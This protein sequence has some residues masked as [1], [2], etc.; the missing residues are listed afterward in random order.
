MC[1]KMVLQYSSLM[2]ATAILLELRQCTVKVRRPGNP[3]ELTTQVSGV[4]CLG[5][6]AKFLR[7]SVSF[8]WQATSGAGRVPWL[9]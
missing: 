6:S 7:K 9:R 2:S 3:L 8:V 5:T 1:M 4:V